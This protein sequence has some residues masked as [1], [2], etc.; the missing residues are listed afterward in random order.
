MCLADRGL[1]AV[2][3]FLGIITWCVELYEFHLIKKLT[4]ITGKCQALRSYFTS[5]ENI[6]Q[7]FFAVGAVAVAFVG[8]FSEYRLHYW[9]Y[10][11]TA[12]S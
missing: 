7:I 5:L 3:M 11:L 6:L 2:F 8:I 1:A 9:T 10:W 12:V 4:T